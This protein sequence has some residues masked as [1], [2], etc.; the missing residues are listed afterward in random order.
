MI[1]RDA[2]ATYIASMR[3]HNY[4][5]SSGWAGRFG[6]RL[7]AALFVVIAMATPV[8]AQEAPSG[9]RGGSI[10]N[11]L[12]L[13]GIAYFLVR[14]FRR[15]GGNDGTRP[16]R[17][18]R[19]DRD[20]SYGEDQDRQQPG[21]VDRH[22]IARQM[23]DLLGSQEEERP[24]STTPTAEPQ[25]GRIHGFDEVEFLEGAKLF[26]ARYQ[27]ACDEL[28]F[29]PIRDFISDDVFNDAMAKG[30]QDRTEVMLLNAKLMELKSDDGRTSATVFYDAQLRKGLQG[31]RTEH[32]REVWEFTRDDAKP[33]ALWVLED[34]NK[35]D[36]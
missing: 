17:W 9:G 5:F 33:G 14:S 18:N 1:A 19:P 12:F 16:G 20:D 35:V 3:T 24:M 13:A 34:I 15:R 26:Y 2:N 28:E 11:V 23:W 10:L 6:S 8:L 21:N 29:Q 32:V 31:E 4:A 27:Q 7:L 25:G 22:D 30:G 36:Q